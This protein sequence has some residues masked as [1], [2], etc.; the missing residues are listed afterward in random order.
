MRTA[1][2]DS[3][4]YVHR[5]RKSKRYYDKG[6]WPGLLLLLK[7]SYYYYGSSFLC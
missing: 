5:G 6:E 1:S 2:N 4:V 3:E 7:N